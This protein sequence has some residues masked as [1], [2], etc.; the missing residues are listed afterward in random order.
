MTAH[1]TR[2]FLA[3]LEGEAR[4]HGGKLTWELYPCNSANLD[5]EIFPR[6]HDYYHASMTVTAAD[7]Y[8][9]MSGIYTASELAKIPDQARH[10]IHELIRN[11]AHNAPTTPQQPMLALFD[12]PPAEDEDTEEP[13][14]EEEDTPDPW[15]LDRTPA[16]NGFTCFDIC[17]AYIY[18]LFYGD[19]TG[20][21]TDEEIKLCDDFSRKWRAVDTAK[22]HNGEPW[23]DEFNRHPDLSLHGYACQTEGVWCEPITPTTPAA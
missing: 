7:L 18:Y 2:L 6:G 17:T 4:R 22:C 10:L 14:D 21:M 9:G 23:T 3:A 1:T 15:E 13:E 19:D 11:R 20:D 5:P 12:D 16:E 8:S